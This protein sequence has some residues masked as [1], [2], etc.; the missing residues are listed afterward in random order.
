[1]SSERSVAFVA[2]GQI[3]ASPP[4]ASEVGPIHW[5]R[6][7]LFDGVVNSILT[8]ASIA[9]IVLIVPPLI[10][11]IFLKGVWNADSLGGCREVIAATH[12][13]GIHGACWA[14][15]NERFNQFMFG[16][17][18]ADLY[19]RPLLAFALMFVALAPVLFSGLPRKMLWLSAAYPVVAYFLIWGGLGMQAVESAQIGGFLLAITI[20]VTGIVA[21]LPI[22]IVLALG[23]QSSMFFIRTICV[24]FI[25]F[26][27]GVPLIT[28][29]FVA[30]VLLNYFLPPG[31]SFD[32]RPRRPAVGPVRGG[33][34]ARAELLE[35]DP[36][37]HHAAS[38][39]GLDSGHRQHLHRAVQGHHAGLGHR[40]AGPGRP[41]EPDPGH[42]AMERHPVGALPVRGG[43]LLDL[44]FLHVPLL[45][46]S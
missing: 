1:M 6:A 4:P 41:A 24:V 10:D 13:E 21:S 42:L 36:A 5:L 19:W 9:A 8:L 35:I 12:G 43:V 27:R 46:V 28:L 31:T 39:E 20:G 2:S 26:V 30:S 32:L 34:R 17:Y 14:V 11:W 29:L 45:D 18:P 22:G 40:A 3:P 37:D 15:I 44:L 16:F 7:N 38:A 23:R 33:R 25:E